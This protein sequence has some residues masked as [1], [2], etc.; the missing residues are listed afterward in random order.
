[1]PILYAADPILLVANPILFMQE[2]RFIPW[3]IRHLVVAGTREDILSMPPETRSLFYREVEPGV[4]V[5]TERVG[6]I[7]GPLDDRCR[8]VLAELEAR[9]KGS[10]GTLLFKAGQFLPDVPREER[11]ALVSILEERLK[12]RELD[13]GVYEGNQWLF[14]DR[15]REEVVDLYTNH[16]EAIADR[17][18]EKHLKAWAV[19]VLWQ[20][21]R[22]EGLWKDVRKRVLSRRELL[23]GAGVA[24]FADGQWL[25]NHRVVD[26]I[27]DAVNDLVH[28][29]QLS[30]KAWVVRVLEED[31]KDGLDWK[32]VRRAARRK[33]QEAEPPLGQAVGALT[34]YDDRV[35]EII[36]EAVRDVERGDGAARKRPREE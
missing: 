5:Y 22:D 29:P 21:G 18:T 13:F 34:L 26:T 2:A 6:R 12:G 8:A 7:P 33:I 3:W 25:Y 1:M 14:D 11:R 24:R 10:K 30:L 9:A 4:F 36:R 32:A 23:Q 19:E 16:R 35:A 27:R 20:M 28:G 17:A 15:V 31:G